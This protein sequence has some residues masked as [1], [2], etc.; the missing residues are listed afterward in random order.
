MIVAAIV[1]LVVGGN[2]W[3]GGPVLGVLLLSAYPQ[4]YETTPSG[5][6]VRAVL[7]R[8]LIPYRVMTFVGPSAARVRIR[9][10]LGSEVLIAPAQQE[11]FLA[12]VAARTP[13]LA[14]RER[15]SSS[16]MP[17]PILT[18]SAGLEAGFVKYP[19]RDGELA[20]Y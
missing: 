5:L 14:G 7:G 13:H 8:Q 9:Y 6:V 20:A 4:T 1:L 11:K 16:I 12:D 19:V 10:G 17:D 3:V 2:Y 18:D 15:R